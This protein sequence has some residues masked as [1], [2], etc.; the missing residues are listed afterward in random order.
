MPNMKKHIIITGA[1][2]GVGRQ[3]AIQL[4]KL[5]HSVTAVA[6]SASALEEISQNHTA[7]YPLQADI[8][9]PTTPDR[10][11]SHLNSEH[12]KIDGLIH[13]AGLLV[14]KPFKKL[15]DQDWLNQAN[16]NFLA[17]VRLTRCLLPHFNDSSHI[18]NISSMGG[19]QG[20]SKFPGLSAYSTTK[21]ALSILTE[22][23]SIELAG[24]G[25]ACNCLCL[26][27]VQTE[28][29]EQAFPGIE[30]PV[31]PEQMGTYIADFI[32]NGHTFYNGKILPVA[33]SNP[34]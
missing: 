25:I 15:T 17:P 32:L 21:G 24:E 1:S 11:I 14:N 29:L 20:S 31:Q 12:L 23:L 33:L 7:I 16:V 3:T 26:G 34:E 6:R 13:N 5:G 10:I 4:A 28:M 30:A 19:F 18:L 8:T 22:C 9:E 2:K 27:A